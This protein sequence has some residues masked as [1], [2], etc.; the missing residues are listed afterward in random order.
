MPVYRPGSLITA[1]VWTNAS[2]TTFKFPEVDSTS[3]YLVTR[4]SQLPNLGIC[5]SGGGLR[6]ASQADGWLRG[7][8]QVKHV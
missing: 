2:Q 7:L 1:E 6:A 8:K 4:L 5:F 3:A